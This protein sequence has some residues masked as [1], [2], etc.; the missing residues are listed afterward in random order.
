MG[1]LSM[2]LS[3]GTW[4]RHSNGQSGNIFGFVQEGASVSKRQSLEI[5]AELAGIRAESNSYDYHAHLASSRVDKE[6]AQ[7]QAKQ[8][9]AS[10]WFVAQDKMTNSDS[11][12]PNKHLKGMMQHNILE[13]VYAYKDARDKLLGYVVRFVGKEDGKKQTLPV[14]YCYNAAKDEYSWR[15]KGFTDKGDKP[16][17]GIEKAAVSSKPIL[18]VEGEKAAVAAAKILPDY[19]VVSWM[20]GSNA[21]DKVNWMG[22]QWRDAIIWPDNDQPGFKAAEV[23]KDKLNKVN[24][25]IGFVSVIDPTHLKFNGSVHKD[26]LPKKW[27]LADRLPEGMTIANIKEAIE[28]VRAAHLDIQQIQSVIQNTNSLHV[29]QRL[30]ERNIWQEVFKGKIVEAETITS[31]SVNEQKAATFFS[32]E[33]ASNYVKYLEVTGKGGV[34]HDYLKFDS[35]M[36]QDTLTSLATR[37]ERLRENIKSLSNG[38]NAAGI[39]AIETKT[40]LIV[41]TQNLYEKRALEYGGI[42]GTHTV[43]RDYLELM[44]KHYGE[45]H[46]KVTLYKNIVRDVSILHSAQLGMNINDV[47]DSH[48]NEI[49]GTIYNN[50]ASDKASNGRGQSEYNIDEYDKI[51]IAA[52][53]YEQLC[54]S[55]VWSTKAQAKLNASLAILERRAELQ[56]DIEN[57]QIESKLEREQFKLHQE[58][59][60]HEILVSNTVSDVFAALEKDQK[61]FVALNDNIKYEIFNSQFQELAEQALEHQEKQLIPK[62]KDVAAAVEHHNVFATEDILAEL[63]GSKDL[64]KTYKHFDSNLERHQLET[65]HQQIRQDKV[66]AKTTDEMLTAI[67]REHEFFKSLD[68]KLKYAEKYDN[69]ILSA[70]S[71]AKTIEQDTLITNMHNMVVYAKKHGILNDQ[72]ILNKFNS[73]DSQNVLNNLSKTCQQHYIDNHNENIKQLLDDEHVMVGTK[74]YTC[75]LK[76][77]KHEMQNNIPSFVDEKQISC[78]LAKVQ[79]EVK[80]LRLERELEHTMTMRF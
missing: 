55:N 33:E 44:V 36:Y 46:E 45:S 67:S 60:K 20:G 30:L 6:Q 79:A 10:E 23:I 5:V 50:V 31:F 62:R 11:F 53:C 27:D 7:E 47:P 72:E 4:I 56:R 14:T 1:R 42:A 74:K 19:S 73:S 52:N 15:L 32:S 48:H 54:T 66:D 3:K 40:K 39:E 8:R 26:L 16:I 63:K 38:N 68:G 51:K 12:N 29:P 70:I 24:D 34:A 22:L 17:F 28:N 77:M 13:A 76:Y 71:N 65:Q 59:I 25:N 35:P 2:N 49:A 64:E 69:S 78:T 21:A 18:I 61:F 57:D 37:D 43:Y 41:D 9:L 80:E 75:P 58:Q